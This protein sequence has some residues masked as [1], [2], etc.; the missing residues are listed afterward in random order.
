MRE[1]SGWGAFVG[2][3][4]TENRRS[5]SNRAALDVLPIARPQA[6]LPAE[7][8][9]SEFSNSGNNQVGQAAKE[10]HHERHKGVGIG[11][12]CGRLRLHELLSLRDSVSRS[13]SSH[14]CCRSRI[15][16]LSSPEVKPPC[17]H[18]SIPGR[19]GHE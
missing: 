1:N 16:Q 4:G 9:L 14:S 3:C 7:R 13:T 10:A 8:V 12:D 5:T 15:A 2:G 17:L 19:M 11:F 18:A 6:K